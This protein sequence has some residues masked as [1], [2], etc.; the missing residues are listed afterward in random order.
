[1]HLHT[2]MLIGS[3]VIQRGKK[4]KNTVILLHLQLNCERIF[5]FSS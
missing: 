5:F 2:R 4:F 1:M 3:R